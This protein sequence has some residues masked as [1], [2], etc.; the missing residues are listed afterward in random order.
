MAVADVNDFVDT[1]IILHLSNYRIT[2]FPDV[3]NI[4]FT[5]IQFLDL[6]S[7]GINMISVD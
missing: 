4:L 6:Q 7:H 3:N 5:N 1:L 2:P